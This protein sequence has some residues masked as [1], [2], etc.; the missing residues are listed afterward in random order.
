MQNDPVNSIGKRLFDLVLALLLALPAV[1]ACTVAALLIWLDDRANPFFVQLRLGRDGRPFRLVKLRTMRI[2]TGDRPSHE[3]THGSITRTGALLRRTKLDELPQLWNVL[4]GEMSFVGPRP[5]LPSQTTLANERHRHGVDRL[6]PGIT[7]VSQVQG[8][9]M[10]TPERL[11]E[12]DADYLRKWSF[13]R[14][15]HLLARTAVGGG[16]GDAASR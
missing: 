6:S 2:G 7:G 13:T 3:T 12:T 8:L 4:R 15:L 14:D 5:G 10:S 16:R 9:D 1:A 11:A